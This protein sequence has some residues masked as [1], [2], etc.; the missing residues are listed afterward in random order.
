MLAEGKD[1]VTGDGQE[2]DRRV[3]DGETVLVLDLRGTGETKP[4]GKPWYHERFGANG[5]NSVLA[6]LLGKSLVGSRAE[7]CLTAV[8]WLADHAGVERVNLV[9]SGELT[10]PALHAAAL[11]PQLF[12]SVELRQG[13]AS[14]SQV[15]ATP[16]TEN[17]IAGLVHGALRNYDLPELAALIEDRLVQRSVAP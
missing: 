6:Y 5:G 17:Q 9:A 15:A 16:I 3:S 13:I 7:D 4:T 14:W 12:E 10:I 11:E 8:R 1:T 2:V